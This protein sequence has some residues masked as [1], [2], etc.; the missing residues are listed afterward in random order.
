MR[1]HNLRYPTALLGLAF[2]ASVAGAQGGK[3]PMSVNDLLTAVRVGDPQLSPDG[4]RV[5]YM[6]TTT[7]IAAGSRNSDIW[8]VPADGSSAPMPLIE[9]PK[10]D[11]S[12]RFIPGSTRV[13]FISSRDGAPQIYTADG[14]GKNAKALTTLSGGVQPPVVVSPDGKLVA[15]ISDVDPSCSDEACNAKAREAAEKDPVKVHTLDRL[16]FRHWDEWWEKNRHHV[17]VTEIASGATHD[18]TPGDFDSPP[19][20]YED[21]AIAF[22][23]D[24][25]EI[26][27][28]SKR[29]GKDMEM[30][31]TNHDVFVVPVA[32]G[33]AKKITSNPAADFQPTYSP[34]GKWLAVRAQR[35]AG[36]EADRWYLDLYD[37]A[38]GTKRTVFETPD[39][40]VDDFRFSADGSRIWFTALDNG[41]TSIYTIP[42]AGG[43]VTRVTQG[44]TIAE[45]KLGTGFAVYSKST[46]VAPAEI[47]RVTQAGAVKQLTNENNSW[48]SATEIPKPASMTVAGAAGANVQYWL[49]KPPRFDASKK[50]P[51]VFL[52]HGGPQGDWGDGWSSRWN[53]AL[54]AAQGW[55]VAAPN[56]RGSTGFGQKFVD[57]ISQ[58]WC[59]KVMTDLENVF[60]AVSKLPYVDA[61]RAGVAGASYGGYAVDWLIGHT[62]RFKVAVSHDGVFNLE[63]MAFATEE[64]WFSEWEFGGPPTSE[65]ARANFARCSPHLSAD[66]I[67]TPTLVITNEQDFRVPV[68][69]GLQLFT[70][71]RRNGV[72]SKGLDFPDEGHWVLKPLNSKRWHEEVFSWMKKYL[73][74]GKVQ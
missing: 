53:P 40:S 46:M 49:L 44:G 64:L 69:Q 4:K 34:D 27:F 61:Q 72:A 2:A 33:A 37:R 18:V 58:D 70:A 31:S 43:A 63:S 42:T 35:R 71:L 29:D 25:R 20:N 57:D 73:E 14:D 67:K 56:P 9:G 32:G 74:P 52:I 24:S 21:A 66:K 10:S 65:K 1:R 50:Y 28:V 26:A 3:R 59:G 7:N 5:L 47:F 8:S 23:P 41:L 62:N 30:W 39:L 38:T 45:L 68:D 16:P 36:F 19:H 15:F 51:V 54:W 11:N 60:D 55:V 48:L 12:P 22:S 6:R 13:L 17:F